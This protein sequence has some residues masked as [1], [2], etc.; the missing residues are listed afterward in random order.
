[1]NTTHDMKGFVGVMSVLELL[2]LRL[3]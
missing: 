3:T 2:T 1:L